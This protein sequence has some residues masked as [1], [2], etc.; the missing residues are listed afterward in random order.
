MATLN[1]FVNM[2]PPFHVHV[3]D[4]IIVI[5]QRVALNFYGFSIGYITMDLEKTFPKQFFDDFM[6][7]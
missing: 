2:K 1:Y 6:V 4:L 5:D 7:I 3:M